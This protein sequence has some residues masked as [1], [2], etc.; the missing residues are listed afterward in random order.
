M[1]S[2]VDSQAEGQAVALF[3]GKLNSL[4]TF[5]GNDEGGETRRGA[6]R[7]LEHSFSTWLLLSVPNQSMEHEL[8]PGE[9]KV[10]KSVDGILLLTHRNKR[11]D[12]LALFLPRGPSCPRTKRG[13]IRAR[14]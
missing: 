7:R 2:K 8:L 13:Q 14:K 9:E 11:R 10:D 3:L 4:R 5:L 1:A 12:G 6:V